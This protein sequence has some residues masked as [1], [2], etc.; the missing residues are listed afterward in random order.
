MLLI[1]N[2]CKIIVV[3]VDY[4]DNFLVVHSLKFNE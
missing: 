2:G 4:F 3:F 1:I